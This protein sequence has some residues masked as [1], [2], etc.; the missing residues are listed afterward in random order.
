LGL[1]AFAAAIERYFFRRATWMETI[2]FIAAAA[3]LLW[4]G[5]LY[6]LVGLAAL[7]A[8]VALQKLYQPTRSASP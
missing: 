3:G 4:P 7:V 2:L 6:D 5:R 1:V 8:A